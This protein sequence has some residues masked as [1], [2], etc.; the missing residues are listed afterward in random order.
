[1]L[2]EHTLG[3][4][5]G[6]RLDGMVRAIEEQATSTAADSTRSPGATTGAW[7]ACSRPPSSRSARPGH[8]RDRTR[9]PCPIL[10]AASGSETCRSE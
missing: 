3:Q 8:P 7:P 1:M 5:R 10:L 6:L 9:A 4:L 2:N